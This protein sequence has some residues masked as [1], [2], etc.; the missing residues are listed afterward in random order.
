MFNFA[1]EKD[2]LKYSP[3]IGVKL[4]SPKVARGRALKLILVTAQRPGEVAGIHANEIGD[5]WWTIPA[6]RAKNGNS[7]RVY[8]TDTAFE[9]IGDTEGKGYIFPTPHKAKERS[10]DDHA[11]AVAVLRNL[12]FPV[13]DGKGKPVMGKGGKQVTENRFGIAKFTPHDLRRTAA[14]FMAESG[15]MDE[16][17]DAIM[18]HACAILREARD[19]SG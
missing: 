5:K 1:V 19:A 16:V 12:A 9:L 17:I 13:V 4:P 3:C 7:H 18:N 8:L 2:L 15:E 10:I 11:L 6:E 14:T